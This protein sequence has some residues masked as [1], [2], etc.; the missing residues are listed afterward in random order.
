MRIYLFYVFLFSLEG[1]SQQMKVELERAPKQQDMERYV[2]VCAC[3]WVSITNM[4][5]SYHEMMIGGS[6]PNYF[7][8]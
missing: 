3:H 6:I 8:W 2:C 4:E 1:S 5:T 7:T